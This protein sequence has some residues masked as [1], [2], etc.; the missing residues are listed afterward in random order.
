MTSRQRIIDTVLCKKT[1]RAPNIIFFDPWPETMERWRGE[2]MNGDDWK[3]GLN[4]DNGFAHVPKITYGYCPPFEHKV[5]EEKDGKI[6][7]QDI[8]G[9]VQE[10]IPGHSGIP[11][12]LDYPVKTPEDWKKLKEERLQLKLDERIGCDL[13]EF[14][15]WAKTADH[16]I[17]IGGFPY[18]LFGTLRDMMGVD[19][20]MY[21]FYDEPEM[22]HDMMDTLTDLWLTIYEEI[23]KYVKVDCIQM[24]EDMS[25]KA[26]PLIS[27]NMMREFMVPNYRKI[28][29][30]CDEH[31][32]P[33]FSMDT[34]GDCSLIF[35][36]LIESGIN[37]LFPLEVQ[38]GSDVVK[39]KEQY[40]D[41][42]CILGGVDKREIS[43]SKEDIDRELARIAPALKV[44]GYIPNFDHLIPPEVSLENFR[45]YQQQ[46]AKLLGV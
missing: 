24:W 17:Q 15:E 20:L 26:G 21:A 37:L 18:G 41:Q 1:D 3:E 29:K 7:F 8:F 27:P 36:I 32:I 34:D 44:G 28:R 11:N 16:I 25:G 4:L 35:D 30:F 19:N 40:P 6:I 45:Y 5:L 42:F 23:C 31:D 33:I 38:A 10:A 9:I 14:G 13:K 2:G 39:I 46:L 43:K 22:I 12:Y